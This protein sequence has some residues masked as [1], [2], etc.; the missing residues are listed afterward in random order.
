MREARCCEATHF[1]F[2]RVAFSIQNHT[3]TNPKEKRAVTPIHKKSTA[4]PQRRRISTPDIQKPA[5]TPEAS[6]TKSTKSHVRPL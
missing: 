2:Y 5:K 1:R 4:Y 6:A 3:H